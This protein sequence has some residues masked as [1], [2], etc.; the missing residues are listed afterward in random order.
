VHLLQEHWQSSK[1]FVNALEDNVR[2]RGAP[3][4]LVSDRAL[5]EISGRALEFLRVHSISSWQSKPHQHHQNYAERKIQHLKQMANTIM[6]RI[7]APPVTWLLCLMY[8]AYVLNHTWDDGIA[9]RPLSA[10]LR[11]TVDTS[12]LLR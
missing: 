5:V 8:V 12:V 1:Q 10:L 6:D 11:I 4:Q 9:G 3:T 7:G 2:A